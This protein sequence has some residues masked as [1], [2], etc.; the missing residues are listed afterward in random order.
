[1][2]FFLF[3]S[4]YNTFLGNLLVD[5]PGLFFCRI[6]NKADIHSVLVLVSFYE[7][8]VISLFSGSPPIER[9]LSI[10][11]FSFQHLQQNSYWLSS[12]KQWSQFTSIVYFNFSFPAVEFD[13]YAKHKARLED[14]GQMGVFLLVVRFSYYSLKSFSV[15]SFVRGSLPF[16]INT[17]IPSGAQEYAQGNLSLTPQSSN[18]KL[19]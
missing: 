4:A 16:G 9:F 5:I 13:C 14:A 2:L 15:S 6:I 1:M 10:I 8:I 3:T 17:H 12:Q 18:F 7:L 19:S 11:D